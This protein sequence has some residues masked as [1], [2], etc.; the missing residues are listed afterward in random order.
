MVSGAVV[1]CK[2][3]KQ[4]DKM[5]E[6]SENILFSW[7]EKCIAG[8]TGTTPRDMHWNLL[9]SSIEQ[10][11]CL[12][13]ARHFFFCRLQILC[14]SCVSVFGCVGRICR[15]R[16]WYFLDLFVF[17]GRFAY[18]CSLTSLCFELVGPPYCGRMFCGRRCEAV[19]EA[20]VWHQI[21][22]KVT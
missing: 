20:K 5:Q 15:A 3:G 22:F 7:V 12:S 10:Q 2:G 9:T 18:V 1:H 13:W 14:A 6:S 17:L 11:E 16:V 4:I 21:R 19:Q 8:S